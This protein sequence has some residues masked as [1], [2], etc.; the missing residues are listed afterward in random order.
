M[1]RSVE[2]AFDTHRGEVEQSQASS[3][4]GPRLAEAVIAAIVA[5]LR[6]WYAVCRLLEIKGT[7][8]DEDLGRNKEIIS[9]RSIEQM[10]PLYSSTRQ[11]VRNCEAAHFFIPLYIFTNSFISKYN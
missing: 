3:Q 10:K 6:E 5:T 8:V 4:L 2:L 9:T 1:L 7:G 11:Q